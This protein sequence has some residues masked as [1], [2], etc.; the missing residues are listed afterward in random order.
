MVKFSRR[1]PLHAFPLLDL[2]RNDSRWAERTR[3]PWQLSYAVAI[4]ASLGLWA[5]IIW[6]IL[7]LL[8]H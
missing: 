2:Y 8:G 5:L 3:I 7:K 1:I 6:G 4:V